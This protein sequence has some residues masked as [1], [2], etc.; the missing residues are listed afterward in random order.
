M[1]AV[2]T[3]V[4]GAFEDHPRHAADGFLVVDHEDVAA[5][6][7]ARRRRGWRR[8]GAVRRGRV[9]LASCGKQQSH[10]G[11]PTGLARHAHRAAVAAQNAQDGREAQSSPGELGREERLEHPRLD[12]GRH[13]AA[14]VRNFEKRVFTLGQ[15]I[16]E[17]HARQVGAAAMPVPRRH[18]NPSLVFADRLDR[19]DD[20]IRQQLRELIGIAVD[21]RQARRE[22]RFQ[23]HVRR[24]RLVDERQPRALTSPRQTGPDHELSASRIRQH[25]PREIGGALR[26]VFDVLQVRARR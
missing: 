1:A 21:R 8:R 22:R 24:Q 17:I 26:G 13:A 18:V 9:P 2:T 15:V 4:L 11:P 16:V 19:V 14:C 3:V 10:G 6:A 23:R 20:H 7:G 12:F 5:G 25:L